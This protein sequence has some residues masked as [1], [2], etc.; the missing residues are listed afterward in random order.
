MDWKT[1]VHSVELT[2]ST[3]G[4]FPK[5][6][7]S[8]PVAPF[9]KTYRV[10]GIPVSYSNRSTRRLLE[11]ALGL[12]DGG[13]RICSL[14]AS[15]YNPKESVATVTFNVSSPRLSG[16][17]SEWKFPFTSDE[18]GDSDSSTGV[19]EVTID[20]HFEGF[21]ALNAVN[22]N[23]EI[24]CVAIT[25]LAG[26]A[27]GSW[28]ERGGGH[29]WLRDSLRHDL[30]GTRVL[31]YGYGS[32]LP[33]SKSFQGIEAIASG[34]VGSLRRIRQVSRL[35]PVPRPLIFIA[36]SLGGLVLK[37]ALIQM[38]DGNNDMDLNNF[39]ATY[40]A[41]FFGVPNRGLNTTYLWAMVKEQPNKTLVAALDPSSDYLRQLHRNFCEKFRF[42]DSKIIS[43]YE[44]GLSPTP[45]L[46]EDGGWALVGEKVML[47]DQSSATESLP[48]EPISHTQAVNR[49]HSDM[50]K[51]SSKD[52]LYQ[53]VLSYLQPFADEALEVIRARFP[54]QQGNPNNWLTVGPSLEATKER[55]RKTLHSLIS[56]SDPEAQYRRFRRMIHRGT[57]RWILDNSN[58][59]TWFQGAQSSCLWCNGIPGAGKT[60]TTSVIVYQ[61]KFSRERNGSALAFFYCDSSEPQTLS[62]LTVLGTFTKQITS[63][64]E[65]LSKPIPAILRGKIEQIQDEG[66]SS[67]DIDEL[68]D[69]LLDL[70][71][72]SLETFFILDGLDACEPNDREEILGFFEQ[73]L[74]IKAP[75]S[76]VK[77]LISSRE[78]AD[79]SRSISSCLQLPICATHTSADICDYVGATVD[80]RIRSKKLI[81]RD[82]ALVTEI[83]EKLTDGAQGMF[84]WVRFQIEDLCERGISDYKIRDIL[85]KLPDGLHETY[86]RC[87]E[88]IAVGPGPGYAKTILKWLSCV[89]RRLRIDELKEVIAFDLGNTPWNADKIPNDDS[90]VINTCANL[91]TLDE[92]DKSVHLVHHTVREFLF[93]KDRQDRWKEFSFDRERTNLEIGESCVRYLSMTDLQTYQTTK[94]SKFFRLRITRPLM[95]DETRPP[96]SLVGQQRLL[97]YARDNWALHT[98]GISEVS[99]VW[100]DFKQ[101]VSQ[102]EGPWNTHSLSMNDPKDLRYWSYFLLAIENEHIPLLSLLKDKL[103]SR[104][105]KRL[106]NQR[107]E[108]GS[109]LLHLSASRGSR[110][111]CEVLLSVCNVN[112]M[113]RGRKTALHCAAEQGQEAVVRLFLEKR[114]KVNCETVIGQTPLLLAAKS[115]RVEVVRLLLVKR[116]HANQRD[117]DGRTPLSWVAENGHVKV[118]QLLVDKGAELEAR[119]NY[120]RTPLRRA[121]MNRQIE[122]V[123]LLLSKGAEIEAKDQF[124]ETPLLS[125]VKDGHIEVILLLL[126]KGASLEAR[127]QLGET[128]LLWAVKNGRPKMVLLLVRKGAKLEAKDQVGETPLLWAIK[129]GHI[130][131]V[132][133]LVR[134]GAKLEAKDKLGQTPLLWAAKNGQ[135][136]M[137]QL[138]MDKDANLEAKDKLDRTPLLWATRKG[139]IEMMQ[140]LLGQGAGLEAKDQ[141]G[142]TPLLWATRRA[143]VEAIQLLL[144][145]DAELEAKDKFGL[146]PLSRAAEIGHTEVAKLLL[147]EGA[148]FEA[149]DPLSW[150]ARNGHINVVQLLLDRG[151]K[152]K[153]KDSV[154]S[155]S[156]LSWAAGGG[157]TNVAQLL[158]SNGAELETKDSEYDRTPLSWASRSGRIEVVRLLL[159]N[160]AELETRDSGC[161]QTALSWA[162]RNGHIKVI[163]LLL[164]RGAALEARDTKFDRSPLVWAAEN[165]HVE[166]AQ[167]LLD[168]QQQQDE[169][170]GL[171]AQD[172]VDQIPPEGTET[173]E[174][175]GAM[176]LPEL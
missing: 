120:G 145:E 166:V 127:G 13:A 126:D 170:T 124:G 114:A 28:K 15:P 133:L 14:A 87:L 55:D 84:L 36:H 70:A 176:P 125:A 53:I 21:T 33:G 106:C 37:Q 74:N 140:L 91:V 112:L 148:E 18:D 169:A 92:T 6:S 73:L 96:I 75:R 46:M 158:L 152:P 88:K 56:A 116:A 41:L 72:K 5:G 150:A 63:H 78:D 32:E 128:P 54:E 121:T 142:Q 9:S 65:K 94:K 105:F 12:D 45:K 97:G 68:T 129:S 44:T 108:N 77:V 66:R 167:L 61:A 104:S 64:F 100:R 110:R 153:T 80:S 43:F 141:L 35:D 103:S 38:R 135:I 131:M 109:F 174:D 89:K 26:H 20:T 7:W 119:D 156:P 102:P 25:G 2:R 173:C 47:V 164:D 4:S 159:D 118:V 17:R 58:F 113:D 132:R 39:N 115:G 137:V 85:S 98:T 30:P 111:S 3:V 31:I 147:D 52:A 175:V 57:G 48:G 71:T 123:Q 117:A 67:F 11:A 146:A 171:E 59:Q 50:V 160:G 40:A 22:E 62:A 23:H 138:L 10:Q 154:C 27:F 172:V 136:K 163:Q 34:L 29:M 82:D 76:S 90:K 155:R 99:L 122:V 24:D 93:L 60:V 49:S 130:E 101:L 1:K 19:R 69:I 95:V 144:D 143:H 86:R 139:N 168:K 8:Q 107:L 162:A 51:F 81:V 42:P 134:K 161:G 151:A 149:T 83:K 157:H 16:G 79:V 165:G